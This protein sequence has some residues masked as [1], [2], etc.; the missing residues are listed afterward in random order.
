MPNNTMSLTR[1]TKFAFRI[2]AVGTGGLG[3][4]VLTIC[5]IS[6]IASAAPPTLSHVFPP[7]AQRGSKL[8][9]TATGSFTWP[10][11]VSVPGIEATPAADSGK[12]ELTIPGDLPADRI[13]LRLFNAEGASTPYPLLV[14]NLPELNEVEPNNSPKSAQKL[15]EPSVTVNGVL[16]SGDVDAFAIPLKA[17][18]RLV[19]A[20]DANTLLGSPIDAMLQIVTP[21]GIVL[22]ENN[23]DLQ[24]D[25]RLAF[26][27]P[28]DGTYIARL[29]A[30]PSTPGTNI[31]YAGGANSVYRLML[32][33]GPVITHTLPLAAFQ[34][35]STPEK[36]AEP[37]L[38]EVA[39]WNIP[40]G[41]RLPVV[42][43]GGERL[44][45]SLEFEPIDDLRN[46]VDA[47]LGLVF[48][49]GF[50]G[51]SRVRL[52]PHEAL[53]EL[54]GVDSASPQS[55]TPSATVTGWLRKPGQ[56]DVFRV[57]LVKGQ[58][59]VV[60]VESRTLNLLVDPVVQLVD[61]AG[62]VVAEVDDLGATQD[63]ALAHTAA[64]D[65][66]YRV[67]VRDRYRQSG[68]RCVYRLTVRL[69]QPDFELTVASEAISVEAA[70]PTELPVKIVRRGGPG[71]PI[72]A[73]T[74]QVMGLPATVTAAP[75]VSESTGPTAA[76][77][78]LSLTT[79]GVAFSGPVRIVGAA[80]APRPMTRAAR[81]PARLGASAEVVWLTAVEQK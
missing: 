14:G 80:T 51:S 1:P 53:T 39:G 16:D 50:A 19:A 3:G 10:V 60:S 77:V 13:W 32:T 2:S 34:V 15:A 24:L 35:S 57:P 63:A 69:E 7:G 22:A 78:K 58:A 55:V 36:P 44:A 6:Q 25:P 11:Q 64:H 4:I 5:G 48:A 59:F 72:G 56:K 62:A 23:D 61:P 27:V 28:R 8:T 47:R 42:P 70:K 45:N 38:V 26:T 33:T 81:T 66:D 54:A 65:G 67:T 17:G 68:E 73:V 76:E 41:T 43:W 71:E 37:V 20:V 49:T 9:V 31:A 21:E 30:F 74:I 18:Q 46:P 40:A 79:T 75:V 12:I 29:F 52:V